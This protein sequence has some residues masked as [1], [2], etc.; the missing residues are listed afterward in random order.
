MLVEALAKTLAQFYDRQMQPCDA[1]VDCVVGFS[2]SS[3]T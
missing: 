2:R 3:C 1:A